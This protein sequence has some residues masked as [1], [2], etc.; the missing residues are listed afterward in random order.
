MLLKNKGLIYFLLWVS[1][2]VISSCSLKY[3]TPRTGEEFL[4]EISR[5][6]KLS[7]E[8]PDPSVR[9]KSHLQLA[10][11]YTYY[12]NPHR[13]YLKA[14]KEFAAYLTL[15]PPGRKDDEVQN[16]VSVLEELK[17]SE[18]EAAGLKGEMGSLTAEMNRQLKK[19][20]ELQ[21]RLEI[22]EKTNRNLSE[23]NRSLKETI[24]MLKK[25]DQQMEEKRRSIR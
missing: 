18:K 22:L 25:L 10:R 19:N 12:K 1:V 11:L 4:Q 23:A 24:E 15:V 3:T 7:V 20:Q 17:K 21:S 13:D 16:W 9:A 14:R 6:E 8:D 5:L 2:L